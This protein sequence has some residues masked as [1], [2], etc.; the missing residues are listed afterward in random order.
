MSDK[1]QILKHSPIFSS[2]DE[3]EL[4]ELTKL[5]IERTFSLNDFIFWEG[6]A[7]EW[8][9]VVTEGK[10][11]MEVPCCFGLVHLAKQA[12]KSSGKDIPFKEVTVG[13]KGDLK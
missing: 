3:D 12:L 11:H 10:V 4:G 5:T 7:P 6:D 2:L 9:Y 8:F 13:V 1:A